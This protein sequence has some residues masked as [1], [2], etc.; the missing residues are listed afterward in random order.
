MATGHLITYLNL[1]F[2]SN[3]NLCHL[4]DTSRQFITDS[5]VEFLTSQFGIQFFI[6]L[7]IVQD[8]LLDKFVL[9]SIGSPFTNL[10]SIVIQIFQSLA[11]KLSALRNHFSIHVVFNTLRN[12]IVS[13]RQ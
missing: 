12:F 4:N 5:K 1:T 13:K 7:Q 3:V 11:T 6:F 10:N 2:L 9:I 8:H